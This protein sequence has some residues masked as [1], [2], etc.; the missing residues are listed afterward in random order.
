GGRA[1]PG[2]A[3]RGGRGGGGGH[4]P[5]GGAARHRRGPRRRREAGHRLLRGAPRPGRARPAGV[6]RDLRPSRLGVHRHVQRGPHR[7]HHPGDLRVPGRTRHRRAPPPPC[8]PPPPAPAPPAN[9]ARGAGPPPPPAAPRPAPPALPGPPRPPARGARAASG[10][11][12][13][14]DARGG[15]TPPPAL[16][17]A[18]LAHTASGRPPRADGIVVT[19]SHNPPS[20]GG[21]KYNPPDGGP[22]GT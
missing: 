15:S 7:R 13:L 12:V 8:R 11:G 14:R 3:G 10:V 4:Q 9:P 5:A 16:S 17:R 19:P 22:A 6:V 18:I 20:D 1:R 2:A 21:F